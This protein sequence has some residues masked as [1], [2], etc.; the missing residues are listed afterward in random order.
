MWVHPEKGQANIAITIMIQRD[1]NRPPVTIEKWEWDAVTSRPQVACH[2]EIA[3]GGGG[4]VSVLGGPL[5]IPFLQ[6]WRREARGPR[7]IYI[8]VTAHDFV[9]LVTYIWSVMKIDY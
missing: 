2:I 5:V 8:V 7:E 6:I 4:T 1:R 3:G 9:V